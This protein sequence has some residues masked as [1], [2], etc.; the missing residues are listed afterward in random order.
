MVIE[1]RDLTGC[2]E[3]RRR[4]H[5]EQHPF[6]ACQRHPSSDEEGSSLVAPLLIP[7]G[8]RH[9][10]RGG[11]PDGGGARWSVAAVDGRGSVLIERRYM[12]SISV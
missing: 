1:G 10:H 4:G 7:E 9:G 11:C 2:G 3:T 5:L 12:L 6:I 8:G